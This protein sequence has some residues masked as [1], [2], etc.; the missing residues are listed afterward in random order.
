[1]VQGHVP[2]LDTDNAVVEGF[3]VGQ[4][5][6]GHEQED[7]VDDGGDFQH[8]ISLRDTHEDHDDE[9]HH[10]RR[11]DEELDLLAD[12]GAA[13]VGD[14]RPSERKEGTKSQNN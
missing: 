9:K 6:E 8:A 10:H 7:E 1:M 12:E 5:R 3:A 11:G 13:E 14:R 2:L 4:Q